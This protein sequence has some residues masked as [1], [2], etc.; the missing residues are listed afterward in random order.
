LR[1]SAEPSSEIDE[2]S[3]TRRGIRVAPSSKPSM[4]CWTSSHVET[5]QKTRSRAA[6][7]ERWVAIL[8]PCF[9]SGSAFERV[10]FHT[11][12][13]APPRARRAAIS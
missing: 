1:S 2:H 9:A 4:T 13:S 11:R 8:A 5:M 6:S 3:I 12:T 7:S 10:R